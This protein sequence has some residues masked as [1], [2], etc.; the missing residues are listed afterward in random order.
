MLIIVDENTSCDV[1][2]IDKA[3]SFF[4][5]ALFYQSFYC[6]SNIDKLSPFLRAENQMLSERFHGFLLKLIPIPPPPSDSRI[7]AWTKVF[8]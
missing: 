2:S 5:P 8:H 7:S 4:D 1:H 3:Q 6:G